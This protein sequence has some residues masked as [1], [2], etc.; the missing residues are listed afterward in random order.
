MGKKKVQEEDISVS[1]DDA[2]AVLNRAVEADREAMSQLF[3]TRI[4]CNDDL[5]DDPTIQVLSHKE[6]VPQGPLGLMRDYTLVGLL[7]IINGI[8]GIR[9]DGWG[10]ITMVT[11][12]EDGEII[13]HFERT[14]RK[15]D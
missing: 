1:V 11:D 15:G 12:D 2:I 7:G 5:A 13:D 10:Y 4:V 14:K 6:L 8:F 3:A 9:K